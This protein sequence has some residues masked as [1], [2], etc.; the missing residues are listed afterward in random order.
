MTLQCIGLE[1]K[2]STVV[3]CDFMIDF[4]YLILREEC[5]LRVF[6]NRINTKKGKLFDVMC[7]ILSSI[8]NDAH[9]IE[10]LLLKTQV[11]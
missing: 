1:F 5:R 4:V 6:G 10:K 9:G 11:S 3:I 2:L 7:I 8:E